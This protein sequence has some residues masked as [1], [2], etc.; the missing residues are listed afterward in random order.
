VRT[1][2]AADSEHY[3]RHGYC[4]HAPAG[5]S[6][7]GTA[8]WL[9]SDVYVQTRKEFPVANSKTDRKLGATRRHK[10][11]RPIQ[12][13]TIGKRTPG[14]RHSRRDAATQSPKDEEVGRVTRVDS[15]PRSMSGDDDSEGAE[16]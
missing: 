2:T 15:A 5:R 16:P 10:A 14:S 13:R 11:A 7:A 6:G 4:P 12:S 8:Y 9:F 1:A 3:R